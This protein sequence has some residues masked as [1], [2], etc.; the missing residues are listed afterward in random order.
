MKEQ[1]KK[2]VQI[3]EKKKPQSKWQAAAARL[4]DLSMTL[5]VYDEEISRGASNRNWAEFTR[6]SSA[7]LTSRGLLLVHRTFNEE[8]S[9]RKK[10]GAGTYF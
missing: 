9:T 1:K 8:L 10:A 2:R 5:K 3:V 7:L 6:E 4:G